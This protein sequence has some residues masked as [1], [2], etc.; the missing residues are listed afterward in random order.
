MIAAVRRAAYGNRLAARALGGSAVLLTTLVVS[1]LASAGHAQ[2]LECYGEKVTV[3]GTAEADVLRGTPRRDVIL[4]LAGDDRILARGGDDIVCGDAGND[5]LFGG[6]GD[7]SISGDA[8]NDAIDGGPG[9]ADEA[10]YIDAP[11]GIRANLS[12]GRASG[13]GRDKLTGIEDLIGSKRRDRLTG[14]D[15]ENLLDGRKGADALRGGP[16]GDLLDGDAGADLLAGG[17]G[18]DV[19]LYEFAPN[20]VNADLG[21]RRAL[22]WG[23]DRLLSIEDLHGSRFGDVLI[24]DGDQ[25]VISGHGGNDLVVGGDGDDEL[26]GERG[27]DTLEGGA[28]RDELRGGRGRDT[29]DGGPGPDDCRT[30]ERVTRCP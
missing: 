14:D 2:A 4:G 3:T 20:A 27:A 8:G 7:D 11:R 17:P 25:N 16:D 19:V 6:P 18:F 9:A 29:L 24:G 13:W 15:A 28:G 21:L 22:G 10:F 23:R 12:T 1:S 30:G 26:E 5:T